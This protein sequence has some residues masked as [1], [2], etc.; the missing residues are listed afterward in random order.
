MPA[1]LE[2]PVD[3][4][5]TS[6]D[7]IQKKNWKRLA[8]EFIDKFYNFLPEFLPFTAN[9]FFFAYFIIVVCLVCYFYLLLIF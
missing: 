5:I 9:Y 1:A 4:H 7:R 3:S 8:K 2:A 6:R